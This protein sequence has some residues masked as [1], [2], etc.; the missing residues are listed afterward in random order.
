MIDA[1]ADQW[2]PDACI[3]PGDLVVPVPYMPRI[4]FSH[5]NGGDDSNLFA[6]G[7]QGR[8]NAKALVITMHKKGGDTVVYVLYDDGK[9]GWVLLESIEAAP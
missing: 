6:G 5:I 2:S 7:L 8:L 3:K 4:I 1:K 9:L